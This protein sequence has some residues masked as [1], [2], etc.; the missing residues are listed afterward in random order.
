MYTVPASTT[1]VLI[2]VESFLVAVLVL[3]RY[4]LSGRATSSS[5]TFPIPLLTGWSVPLGMG[6]AAMLAITLVASVAAT[7]R[8]VSTIALGI[9]LA[10]AIG[11]A[12]TVR[13]VAQRRRLPADASDA[14]KAE[15]DE[16]RH[17][18][19]TLRASEK[20]FREI[21]SAVPDWIWLVDA[22]GRYTYSSPS[23]ERILG[24][25][26][27][28]IVGLHLLEPVQAED[29][30][31][32]SGFLTEVFRAR[33]AFQN[34][35]KHARRRDGHDIWLETSAV[36]LL[37]ERGEFFGY[38]GIDRDITERR[39]QEEQMLR[40]ERLEVARRIAGQIAH[41]LNNLIAP[42]VGYPELIRMQLP[43][44]HS[45]APLCDAMLQAALQL[46]DI[47][48]GLQALGQRGQ[49][50]EE[51]VNLNR[52]VEDAV[53][54]LADRPETLTLEL[55]L[56]E[57][58]LPVS[59]SASQLSLAVNRLVVNARE[60]MYDAGVL[61]VTTENV[62]VDEPIGH[63]NRV[64]M[65]EYVRLT[66]G[67][68]GAGIPESIRDKIFDPFFTTKRNG[69]RPRTGLGLSLVQAV[70]DDHRGYVDVESVVGKGTSFSLYL[71]VNREVLR[72]RYN[73]GL[74]GGNETILIV[75]DDEEQVDLTKQLLE[76]LG[77]RVRAVVNGEEGIAFLKTQAVD[78]VI[79]DMVMP[80]G[81]DGLETYRRMLEIR[82]AQRAIIVSGYAESERV[83]E[84]QSLGAGAYLRKPVTLGK[85]ARAVRRELNLRQ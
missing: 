75:D 39:Q 8:G 17:Q 51:P 83:R 37:D 65:G 76:T 19:E 7:V 2:L 25:P 50:G 72:E 24:Y 21:A 77:Y 64:E 13:Q 45:A 11:T 48:E 4:V 29:G 32:F 80:P 31:E 82:P 23:V 12:L 49:P 66:V 59:G 70:V 28:E 57:D 58:L 20:H 6:L 84:A 81:I 33:K 52:L 27:E 38:C 69:T 46:A 47:N 15:V 79:L 55:H 1:T 22:R 41:D 16:L 30:P 78:L 34:V 9:F 85:L 26:T 73:E 61:T 62:Y 67:D 53:E 74:P 10:L 18:L 42:L 60:S 56:A 44:G 36:P 5:S 71:P 35:P 54:Q 63:F 3:D 40:A 14:D 43:N 68:T